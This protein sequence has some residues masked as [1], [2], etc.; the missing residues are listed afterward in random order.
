MLLA[1]L[2]W[3]IAGVVTRHLESAR[4]FEVTFW[5]SLFAALTLAVLLGWMRGP[6]VLWQ[7]VRDGGRTL[8]VSGL[9]WMTMFT[10]Y[11]VALT[12]TTVANV[13]I[14]L[15]LG[16]L[17]TALIAW[18]VLRHR[19]A[20]R[21]WLA[22]ALAGIGIAWMY[23]GEIGGGDPRHLLGTAIALCVPIAAAVNWN[24][25]QHNRGSDSTDMLPAVLI[26]AVLSSAVT[27]LLAVPFQASAHDL[28]LLSTLGVVQLAVPCLVAVRAARVLSGPEASLLSLLEIIFG[29]AWAW[30]GTSESPTLPVL[31]GGALVLI[32][33]AANEAAALRQRLAA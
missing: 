19:L 22:I 28:A 24:V 8:W 7:S 12:L 14:T 20:A 15:A 21:T 5:R 33:L 4:S 1:T 13:L 27:L 23:A 2:M 9:C 16:P 3:S 17:F 11:M 31:G 26:G 25:L 32:A 30:L 10:A 18:G 6:R 29:V